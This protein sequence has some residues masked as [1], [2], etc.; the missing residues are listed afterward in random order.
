MKV[1]FFG[2]SDRSIPIIKALHDSFELVLCI[3]KTD[4]KA[5]RKQELKETAVKTWAKKHEVDYFCIDSIKDSKEDIIRS[6][7]NHKVS[8]GAVAD[9]SFIIPASIIDAP[10]HG[11]INMHFSLLPK[12]R[13]ASPVQHAILQGLEETGITY[14]LMD[15]N[16]DTGDILH[17]ISYPLDQTETS[18]FLYD[19]LFPLAAENLL[20]V[21]ND[22]VSG[23]TKPQPQNHQDATYCYSKTRPQT[24]HVFKDDAKIDWQEDPLYI[25]RKI[26]AFYPWPVAWTTLGKLEKNEKLPGLIQLKPSSYANLRVKIISAEPSNGKL[27]IKKLQVEG[28]NEIDW[29]GF[30]NGYAMRK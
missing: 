26:R 12:L 18:G 20:Q 25:E 19:K 15:E 27:K 13:G 21:I 7:K 9:F 2:T 6:L 10:K 17:Q 16:M 14:Y 8:L 3:T 1:A 23:K 24:T 11:L 28:K 5:G 29:M 22:Y 4:T 30:V